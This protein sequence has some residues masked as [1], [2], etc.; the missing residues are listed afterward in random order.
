MRTLRLAILV[1]A[2]V[3]LLAGSAL[4]AKITI[5]DPRGD[6]YGPGDYVYPTDAV[7]T[8]GSFDLLEFTFEDKGK[9]WQI[10]CTVAARL[11]DPWRMGSGFSVQMVFVFI[12]NAP[13]GHTATPPGLNVLMHDDTAWDK[14]VI[15]SPQPMA[16]VQQEVEAKAGAMAK[17]IVTPTRVRGA[18]STI[19]ARVP[20]DAIGAGDPSTWKFQVFMQS[21]EGFPDAGD[22]LTRKVNEFEGQHRFGGGTDFDC[23]PH[24][25]D[26]LG[27]HA[28]LKAYV[29]NDDGTTEKLAV[30]KM[31]SP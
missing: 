18:R 6:D 16:R 14:C 2:A 11:E 26:I 7:Y 19:T 25:I 5:K 21:N 1:L 10:D 17:D 9:E 29:C 27:D 13:G 15:L 23:D 12:D 8:P 22:L 31:V 3:G 20:K 28:Q 30:V 4:A 24:A